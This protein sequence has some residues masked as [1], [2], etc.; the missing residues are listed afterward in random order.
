MMRFEWNALRRGDSVLVHDSRTSDLRL[1]KG[2]VVIV[3]ARAGNNSVA[4]RLDNDTRPVVQRP[5]RLWVHFDPADPSD[6]C[7]RCAQLGFDLKAA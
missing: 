6:Y 5:R 2:T 4:V 1:V 3:E 7:W